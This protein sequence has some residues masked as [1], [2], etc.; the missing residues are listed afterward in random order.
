[1]HSISSGRKAL[2]FGLKDMNWKMVNLSEFIDNYSVIFNP[3]LVFSDSDQ[4]FIYQ[5]APGPTGNKLIP[6]MAKTAFKHFFT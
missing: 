4:G 3:R 2:D 5:S 6:A 1:M